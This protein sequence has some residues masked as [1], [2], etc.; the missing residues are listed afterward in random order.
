MPLDCAA[1]QDGRRVDDIRAEQISDHLEA[2]SG[3][4]L[5]MG[6]LAVFAGQNS[7]RA[8]PL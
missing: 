4:R 6:E 5:R 8:C 7:V 2:E 1:Y 3:V